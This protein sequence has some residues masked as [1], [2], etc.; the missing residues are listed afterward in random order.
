MLTKK[1]KKKSHQKRHDQWLLRFCVL[2]GFFQITGR[3]VA[4]GAKRRGQ[5]D[6]GKTLN[7]EHCIHYLDFFCASRKE[8]QDSVLV[9]EPLSPALRTLSSLS[10]E[11]EASGRR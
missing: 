9:R 2:I 11:L 1:K 6:G 10:A 4:A 5:I 7:T 8:L 3:H